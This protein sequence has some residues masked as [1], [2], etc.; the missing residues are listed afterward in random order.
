MKH[1]H[2]AIRHRDDVVV[3]SA[4]INRRLRLLSQ[5]SA[6]ASP[7]FMLRRHDVRRF[8]GLPRNES[9]S[10]RLR[11]GRSAVDEQLDATIAMR[12]GKPAMVCSA[13]I[14]ESRKWNGRV[15]NEFR[16]IRKNAREDTRSGF[17]LDR[18][19]EVG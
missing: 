18:A 8:H 14:A 6:A 13:F 15:D 1:E 2:I 5:N 12:R 16:R 11:K 10:L 19:M 9:C 4:G 17:G 7:Q 3:K